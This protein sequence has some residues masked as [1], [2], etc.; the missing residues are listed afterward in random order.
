MISAKHVQMF[1]TAFMITTGDSILSE[2]IV[3]SDDRIF[4]GLNDIA[5]DGWNMKATG[6]S[7]ASGFYLEYEI[8]HLPTSDEVKTIED[9]INKFAIEEG[10][11]FAKMIDERRQAAI[12]LVKERYS[13][14]MDYNDTVFE[15]YE[16]SICRIQNSD[17]DDIADEYAFENNL[18]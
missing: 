12:A 11:K 8:D 5:L 7:G 13:V 18:D 15:Y 2:Y 4:S 16:E 3:E 14:D 6:I 17:I 9:G 1:K 10:K